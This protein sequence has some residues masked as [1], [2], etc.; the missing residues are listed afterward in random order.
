MNRR[1]VALLACA[2]LPATTR[3]EPFEEARV[4]ETINIVSLLQQLRKPQPA[5]VGDIIKGQTALKTGGESRAELKFPDL[6]ITRV[7]SNS[8]FRFYA[9][10]RDMT[11][12]GGTMLFYSPKG[13]GG[14]KVQAGAVT[15][16]V[17]G[18]ALSIMNLTPAMKTPYVRVVCLEHSAV[19]SGPG[20]TRKIRAGQ[21]ID[22]DGT[23]TNIDLAA[24][25]RS[26]N[27][28]TGFSTS[29]PFTIRD[30][31][32][33]DVNL[34]TKVD[35]TGQLARR[36][37]AADQPPVVNNQPTQQTAPRSVALPVPAPSPQSFSPPAPQPTPK[38]HKPRKHHRPHR[39]DKPPQ[40][41]PGEGRKQGGGGQVRGR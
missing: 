21:L 32:R 6:T 10:G 25:A 12:D 17:T 14:G 20:F 22:Q 30:Y 29:L 27:L 1:I 35:Q 15:A 8:L 5:T 34:D 18:S 36:T 19:V 33:T 9:G 39:P 40:E 41:M 26:S 23:V 16:A 4:T 31:P 38:P 3:A 7:G 2:V 37:I 13:A 28:F 24:F 11:L